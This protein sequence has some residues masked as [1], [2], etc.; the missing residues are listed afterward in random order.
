[1]LKY[2]LTISSKTKVLNIF[3]R[4]FLLPF[5]DRILLYA[6]LNLDSS[7]I[8]KMVPPNYLYRKGSIKKVKRSGINY[9]LDISNVVDHSIYFNLEKSYYNSI[10]S[11]IKEAK[12]ILDIGGN[13]GNSALYFASINSMQKL[14]LLN[15]TLTPS[16]KSLKILASILF[17]T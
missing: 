3:R 11:L 9:F 15:L 13:I 8:K 2:R 4:I 10:L 14:F 12:V 5:F 17:K 1:M 7:I 6:S 16:K